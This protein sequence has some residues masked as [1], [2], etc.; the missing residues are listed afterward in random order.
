M[1]DRALDIELA[2]LMGWTVESEPDPI[3]SGKL[4]RYYLVP[5]VQPED[6]CLRCYRW[7]EAEA[8]QGSPDFTSSRDPHVPVWQKIERRGLWV[9]YVTALG[10]INRDIPYNSISGAVRWLLSFTPEQ[11]TR[12]AIETLKGAK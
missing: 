10:A 2:K 4:R 5:P 11:L 6:V 8:W 12:A 9:D 1:P 3:P 7:T